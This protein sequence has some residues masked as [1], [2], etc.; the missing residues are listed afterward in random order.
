M[1]LFINFWYF[2]ENYRFIE[3]HEKLPVKTEIENP[4]QQWHF[5]FSNFGD[6]RYIKNYLAKLCPEAFSC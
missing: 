5:K 2:T 3:K 6:N 4:A 1:Y